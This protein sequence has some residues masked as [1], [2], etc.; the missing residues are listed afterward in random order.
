MFRKE[1]FRENKPH[2]L[3]S[4][5]PPTPSPRKAQLYILIWKNMVE[6]GKAIEDNI[7]RRMRAACW[8]TKDRGTHS[9]YV[10]FIAFPRPQW[11]RERTSILRH[12]YIVWIV[13]FAVAVHSFVWRLTW[14]GTVQDSLHILIGFMYRMCH[15]FLSYSIYVCEPC[16]SVG[17][18]T[19]LRAGRSADRIPVGGDFPH[20]SRPALVPTQ[21]PVQ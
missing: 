15:S 4:E 20:L 10:I 7:K 13:I 21:P 9:E 18:A 6:P 2:I 11:L 19:E 3:C 14:S 8:V 12:T 5:F 1:R 17:I 16:S